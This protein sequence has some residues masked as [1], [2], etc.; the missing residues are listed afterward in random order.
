LKAAL[1]RTVENRPACFILVGLR[2][3]NSAMDENKN[4]P[5]EIEIVP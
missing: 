3:E 2:R 1:L 4:V 5:A